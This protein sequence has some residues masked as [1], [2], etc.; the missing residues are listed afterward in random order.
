MKVLVTGGAGFIG[1]NLVN[2]LLLK[3]YDVRLIDSLITG[4]IEN[5]SKYLK[6]IEFIEGDIRD[7]DTINNIVKDVEIIYH[8]AAIPSVPYTIK[9]PIETNDI[10]INGTLNILDASIKNNVKRIIFASSSSIYGDSLA[11]PKKEDMIPNPLSHYAVSKLAGENYM[12]IY[13][14]LFGLETIS[15]RYFNVFGTGQDPS[16]EYSAVIPKFI[17][18]MQNNNRPTIFGDGLQT[19]DFT[20]VQNVVDANIVASQISYDKPLIMNCA[21]NCKISLIELVESINKILNKSIIPLFDKP[22]LGDIKHS[23]ADNTVIEQKLKFF[24]KVNFNDGLIKTI[25]Y[26]ADN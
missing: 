24:P 18:A 23:Y 9:N 6:H 21:T 20:Y 1:S 19:R 26:F 22:Q 8:L 15:F 7:Y 14:K 13:S 4:R 25:N 12:N 3:G 10:H 11:L 5:I 2:E 17:K 16:S